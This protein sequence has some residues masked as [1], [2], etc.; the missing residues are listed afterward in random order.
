[1]KLVNSIEIFFLINV[2]DKILYIGIYYESFKRLEENQK[3]HICK[4]GEY[5]V[6]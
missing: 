1:M 3:I 6:S 4:W 2:I 5:I